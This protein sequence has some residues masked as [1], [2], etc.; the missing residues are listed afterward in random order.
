MNKPLRATEAFRGKVLRASD[1]RNGLLHVYWGDEQP[2]DDDPDGLYVAPDR[3]PVQSSPILFPQ[4]T[5]LIGCKLTA[6]PPTE[7]L[8]IYEYV[9]LWQVDPI[10]PFD[11]TATG[12]ITYE[13]FN[14]PY[15]DGSQYVGTGR[16]SEKAI[17]GTDVTPIN[18][19]P[20]LDD[21]PSLGIAQAYII[22]ELEANAPGVW[23]TGTF[24]ITD[25]F[26]TELYIGEATAAGNTANVLNAI[27]GNLFP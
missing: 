2:T 25:T 3:W 4:A 27:L 1:I 22:A 17:D 7:F 18:E 10:I 21:I 5:R 6:A 14:G 11:P 8:V 15:G 24:Q 23:D 13:G 12:Q 9:Y 19:T 26:I 20:T 16:N